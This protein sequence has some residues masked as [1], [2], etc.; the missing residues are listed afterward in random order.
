MTRYHQI[1]L[2]GTKE[3][4]TCFVHTRAP[5]R[6][7]RGTKRLCRF[8]KMPIAPHGTKLLMDPFVSAHLSMKLLEPSVR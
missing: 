3:M 4:G 2:L 7:Q 1:F 5:V 6:T 8:T